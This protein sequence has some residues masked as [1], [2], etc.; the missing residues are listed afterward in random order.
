MKDDENPTTCVQYILQTC[1]MH[2]ALTVRWSKGSWWHS[3]CPLV[4]RWYTCHSLFT[5]SSPVVIYFFLKWFRDSDAAD[6]KGIAYAVS[7]TTLITLAAACRAASSAVS[8]RVGVRAKNALSILAFLKGQQLSPDFKKQSKA[9][10]DSD[11]G[12]QNHAKPNA[13]SGSN[14]SDSSHEVS[15]HTFQ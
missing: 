12:F 14:T 5:L 15:N 8:F 7:L 6:W 2:D 3:W 10:T 1:S 13:R 9:S 4:H 11:D